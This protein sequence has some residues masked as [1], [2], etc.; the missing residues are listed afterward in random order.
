[1][2][3]N[4]K[5]NYIITPFNIEDISGTNFTSSSIYTYAKIS[6]Y[7]FSEITANSVRID[8]SGIYYYLN[9]LRN[10]NVFIENISSNFYYDNTLESNVQ[11][12]Y[13]IIAYNS[14]NIQ[15]INIIDT[16]SFI[17]LPV[18]NNI[19]FNNRTRTSIQLNIDG[20]FD[21]VILKKNNGKFL[22]LYDN[23]KLIGKNNIEYIDTNLT[24]NTDYNYIIT[25]YNNNDVSG[26]FIFTDFVYTLPNLISFS[27]V[28]ISTNFVS[29]AM[30]GCYNYVII[31]RYNIN[32]ITDNFNSI[33]FNYIDKTALPNTIYYYRATSVNGDGFSGNSVELPLICTYPQITNLYYSDISFNS[34]AINIV[35]Y[36]DTIFIQRND[37]D[38]VNYVTINYTTK[39]IDNTVTPDV[40]YQYFLTPYNKYNQSLLTIPMNVVYTS[41][42]VTNVYFDNNYLDQIAINIIGGYKYYNIKRY[43]DGFNGSFL[44]SSIIFDTNV[45]INVLYRYTITPFNAIDISG[46]T[47]ITGNAYIYP[48]I[49]NINIDQNSDQLIIT[50]NSITFQNIT[51][52]YFYYDLNRDNYAV[53][54]EINKNY[55]NNISYIDSG[56]SSNTFYNY[57]LIPYNALI[58]PGNPYNLRLCTMSQLNIITS[59]DFICYTNY[60]VSPNFHGQYSY[61]NITRNNNTIISNF[62]GINFTDNNDN[63]Y[64]VANTSVDYTIKS[65]NKKDILGD[66]YS[67]TVWTLPTID[68]TNSINNKRTAIFQMSLMFKIVGIFNNVKITRNGI[69]LN[70]GDYVVLISDRNDN[71][72]FTDSNLLPSTDY[73]YIITPYNGG[74]KPGATVSAT[75]RTSN[76]A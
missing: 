74:D 40:S 59:N 41:A 35:G 36:Y 19:Y 25:P 57:Q 63:N 50:N 43:D 69:S 21:F 65:Y 51:G 29:F 56:L 16:T 6:S 13:K 48:V 58:L 49:Y 54:T 12:S 68:I 33:S 28:D 18:L 3:I 32:F 9:L 14:D 2:N 39:Y 22:I 30:D 46:L 20:T 5:Y 67:V 66:N 73:T 27:Y 24:D 34:I 55:V 10:D 15:T 17:T 47:Y 44:N 8:L 42:T 23:V 38:N 61:L 45:G 37:S 76:S 53:E 64:Y 7:K 11:Y 62:T 1:M 71:N 31:Q 60:I 52:V 26:Q 70:N 72:L 75:L 4:T